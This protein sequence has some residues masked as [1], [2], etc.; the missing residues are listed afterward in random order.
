MDLT[1]MTG[2]S[3]SASISDTRKPGILQGYQ[4]PMTTGRYAEPGSSSSAI[5]GGGQGKS[6][7]LKTRVVIGG[8][9]LG[10]CWKV[11]KSF[12]SQAFVVR[13]SLSNAQKFP[14][15]SYHVA[16]G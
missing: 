5:S 12:A 14:H 1:W 10:I 11:D 13:V 3:G 2:L 15:L 4:S 8:S 6:L 7:K 16:A 9:A